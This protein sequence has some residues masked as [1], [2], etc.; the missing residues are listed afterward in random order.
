MAWIGLTAYNDPD[1]GWDSETN[2]YDG[3]TSTYAKADKQD[4]LRFLELSRAIATVS[5][6][7]IAASAYKVGA[8]VLECDIDIYYGGAW[9]DL[10]DSILDYFGSTWNEIE[11]G[12]SYDVTQ[13]RV[14]SRDTAEEARIY[15]VELWEDE[16]LTL[17]PSGI[18]S[19][20]AFGTPTVEN[21]LQILSPGGIASTEAFGATAVT[22]GA[23]SLVPG[24]IA[25]L[26]AFG[27]PSLTPHNVLSPSSIASA[28]AFDTLTVTPGAV[29]LSPG[30]I[31]SGEVLDTPTVTPGVWTLSLQG[32]VSGEAFGSAIVIG[33]AQTL[34]PGGIASGEAFG[35]PVVFMWVS[36]TGFNDPDSEWANE[37]YAYD[38]DDQTEAVE[39]TVPSYTWSKFLELTI[40]TILCDR[41]KIYA[42]A[43]GWGNIFSSV[44][45]D[46]YVDDAWVHAYEGAFD[47]DTGNTYHWFTATFTQ[48]EVSKARIRFYCDYF[49]GIDA[50]LR[51][52]YFG[53]IESEISIQSLQP[54]GISSGEA[55]GTPTVEK[56]LQILS[57]VSI[58]S[59]EAF[60]TPQVNLIIHP[61]GIATAEAFTPPQVNLN[62]KPT[63]ISSAEAFGIS[64]VIPGVWTLT[65]GGIASGEAFGAPA[66][67]PGSVV[68]VTTGIPSAESFGITVVGQGFLAPPGISSAEAF[69]IPAVI[70]KLQIL[71]P[72]GISSGEA[73]G[74]PQLN[75]FVKPSGIASAEAFDTP[76]LNVHQILQ[77]GGI[78]SAE[79]FGTA[80]VSPGA[81]TLSPGGIASAEAFG[82]PAVIG[83]QPLSPG[84]IASGE[85]FGVPTVTPGA[86]TLSPT[87]I[88]SV[89]AFGIPYVLPGIVTLLPPGISSLEAFGV[90]VAVNPFSQ[91]TD[92]GVTSYAV[93]LAAYGSAV[94]AFRVTTT[95][96]LYRCESSNNGDSWGSWVSMGDISGGT[97][98]RLAACF[99]D[100]DEALV[101][102]TI[103]GTL[104]RRRWNGS[105]WETA[106]AWS[107]T[108]A[109][110]TGI[111]CCYMGDWNVVVTGTDG[112]S[113]AG[114]W[115]CVLGNGYSAAVDSWSSLKEVMIAESGSN[116]TYTFPTL[117]FPDVFRL[118]FV[119]AYSGS[120]SYSRPYWS[121]SYSTADFISNLWREPVP[122]NLDSGYGLALCHK[123]P[124]VFLSRPDSVW[125]ST[126]SPPFVE[127]TGSLLSVSSHISPFKGGVDITLRNFD[128][129][130]NTLGGGDYAAIKKGSEV[131][132]SWGYRTTSG[133]ET[134]GFDPTTWIESWEYVTR[135]AVSD[136]VLHCVDGWSLLERW[137]A[138]RQFTWA[139]GTKNIYQLL[140][141]IF[142][143]AGLELSAY[144]TSTALVSLYPVFTINPGESGL[145]AVKRLLSMVTDVLFFVNDTCYLKNPKA[146]D[147]STYS[148]GTDHNIME[149]KYITPTQEVNRVQVFGD[150]VFTEDWDWDEISQVYDQ[151]AQSN[152]I[153]LDSTTKAHYRGEAVMREADIEGLNGTILVPMNCG[154]DLFDVIAIT[155]PQAGL[156]ASKRRVLSLDRLWRPTKKESR[157]TLSIGLGAP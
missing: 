10:F 69:G 135:G 59:A 112:D 43:G 32:I 89:E 122:F 71:Q 98:T 37:P 34:Q 102:Y 28:E 48:A 54:G 118:F 154:Q 17:Q 90:P 111:A 114:V 58:A 51:D 64:T 109:T 15:E 62:I 129:R 30:G 125:R 100:A 36:P 137:R 115:T 147:A 31:A 87:G 4:V 12:A 123:S 107:N 50:A 133:N 152:D 38:D 47:N 20:E 25:S 82:T 9:H 101:L 83:V 91:W 24:G 94:F 57:A 136:L 22:P 132:L 153:N 96:Y 19:A 49:I 44:D 108:L 126:I 14:R 76:T 18:A 99:K 78:P 86:V 144:S 63:G 141:M 67:V 23:V 5:K 143:R 39:A 45:I 110:I 42:F 150:G 21:K 106:A 142:G 117:D 61:S 93:A 148:Y 77:P 149:G 26:E 130:F 85:A 53:S 156:S 1:S 70:R 79:A 11:I 29:S 145:T 92:T 146:I 3:N 131:L 55:F 6:L 105:T 60:S 2:A 41:V 88:T 74:V 27:A 134:G 128:G 127:L 35:I 81:V 97:G 16:S 113:K 68:L 66:V 95:G 13:V 140:A 7:R 56:K 8:H 52:L 124:S 84:G 103:G 80:V 119:E 104:Y 75:L 65:P 116:I 155:S 46:V 139:A 33:P 73:F 40:S 138:R 157:Y 120:E 72:G 151:L 121:H